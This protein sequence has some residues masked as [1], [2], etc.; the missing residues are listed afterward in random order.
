M[1]RVK[2]QTRRTPEPLVVKAA[3]VKRRWEEMVAA[4]RKGRHVYVYY[5]GRFSGA[6]IGVDEYKRLLARSESPSAPAV[7]NGLRKAGG[8]QRTRRRTKIRAATKKRRKSVSSKA[9]RRP[10]DRGPKRTARSPV[11]DG[12]RGRIVSKK[13]L[14]A[15]KRRQQARDRQLVAEGKLP[16]ESMLLI[17][18][19]HLKG[20][21]IEWPDAPLVDED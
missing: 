15:M 20:A 8:L 11:S 1:I 16:P 21:R 9:T 7:G 13:H 18:P 19:E 2:R 4:A 5:R 12:A 6:L 17:R 3:D 14:W 10:A